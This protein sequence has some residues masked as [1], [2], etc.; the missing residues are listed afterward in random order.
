MENQALSL[1]IDCSEA[2]QH[3]IVMLLY[4]TSEC[5]MKEHLICLVC[6]SAIQDGCNQLSG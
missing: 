2:T 4:S 5:E 3:H 1:F 6:T